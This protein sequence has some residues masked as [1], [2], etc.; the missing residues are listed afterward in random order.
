MV[1]KNLKSGST[2]TSSLYVTVLL[3]VNAQ[4]L[5]S[6]ETCQGHPQRPLKAL[7]RAPEGGVVPLPEGDAFPTTWASG[8]RLS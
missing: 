4:R 6:Q 3:Q 5:L 8:N 2:M 7:I 1:C